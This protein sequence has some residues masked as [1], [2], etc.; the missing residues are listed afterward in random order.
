[1]QTLQQQSNSLLAMTQE[2]MNRAPESNCAEIQSLIASENA[3]LERKLTQ[4][5]QKYDSLMQTNQELNQ[6][7]VTMQGERENVSSL[8]GEI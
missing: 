6:F 4:L 1:M 3:N 2:L 7:I 5:W 8:R